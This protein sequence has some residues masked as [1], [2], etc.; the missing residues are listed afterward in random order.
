MTEF[1]SLALVEEGQ[2]DE[3]GRDISLPGVKK[4]DM[5]MRHWKPEVRVGCVR[6]SPTG[7]CSDAWLP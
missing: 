6:F 1:G 5:S 4:G 3:D 2:G 7:R